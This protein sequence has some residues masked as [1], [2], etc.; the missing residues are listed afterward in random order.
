MLSL[1]RSSKL[2]R[3]YNDL[4]KH[5]ASRI[6]EETPLSDEDQLIK[7]ACESSFYEFV[8]HAW[9]HLDGR[10]YVDGWHVQAICEHLQAMQQMEIKNLLINLPPRVGKSSIVSV[11][12]P[13]WCWSIDPGL[14]FLYT[15][16]AQTL[17]VRDSGFCRGL[18][19][20]EWYQ[21]LW[22]HEYRISRDVN[23]KIRF[24]NDKFGYR[25]ASSVNGTITGQGGDIICADDPNSIQEVHSPTIR[26]SVND[27]WDYVFSTRFCNPA[28][29]RKIL[30]QQ[31]SHQKDL[32][33]HILAKNN[34][35][36]VILC[37]P[38]E[39]EKSRCAVT[40]P[41]PMSNG[42][43]WRDPRKKE[44]ELLWPQ[45]MN[46]AKVEEIKN[47]F[48]YDSYTIAS[49]LQQRP[50]PAEGGILK[51]EWFKPWKHKDLPEF[52]FIL[53]SWDTALTTGVQSCYSACTTWG[54]FKDKG[55]INNIMLLSLF[56]EKV[57]YPDLRK[58]AIR[59]SENYE[60]SYFDE[61]IIGRNPPDLILIEAKVNGYSL[62]QDLMRANLPVMKFDPKNG[63]KI[64]RCRVVSHLMENGLVWLPTRAPHC[65]YYTN[66]SQT[67]LEAA[68]NFPSDESNDIIDS[69][70]QA[71]QRLKD[72]GWVSNKSDPL[73]NHETDW[74]QEQ[75]PY[76]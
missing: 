67:F 3:L 15:S 25:Q 12:F 23:N 58:A 8:K 57:E 52:E 13:A 35:N 61:P 1:R 31:R 70:S 48:N 72:T 20:S 42:K 59:L 73:D 28:T 64:G 30:V 62:L 60:D 55:G 34:P 5:V 75:R 39:F 66:D 36:W 51:A 19:R 4:E 69:M 22:G 2:S 7:E 65:E 71:F 74:R 27:W 33:G 76:S 26:D 47:E 49:Q 45:W 43:V 14:R 53:Q 10:P 32:T 17:S 16:Y 9:I 46:A 18:I 44:G 37:L 54:I 29:A 11:A 40:V 50:S 68:V 6:V 41:L 21:K 56:R 63:N 38:M 24:H